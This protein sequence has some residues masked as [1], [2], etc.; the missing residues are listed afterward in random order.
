MSVQR[1]FDELST[2]DEPNVAISH[3]YQLTLTCYLPPSTLDG[4]LLQTVTIYKRRHIIQHE[5]ML[6]TLWSEHDGKHF[7]ILVERTI[8]FP[9]VLGFSLTRSRNT[10]LSND[11][12]RVLQAGDTLIHKS[13]GDAIWTL[14][15]PGV[16][17]RF[18]INLL[19]LAT[20]LRTVR[21]VD[22]GREYHTIDRNCFW[23]VRMA[24]LAII[25]LAQRAHAPNQ[26]AIATTEEAEMHLGRCG[27]IR[28][29]GHRAHDQDDVQQLVD[30]YEEVYQELRRNHVSD[31]SVLPLRSSLTL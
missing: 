6:F 16:A 31:V 24:R 8:D 29:D 17:S 27:C 3:F 28:L 7:Q 1:I 5:A 10:K 19:Q 13:Y 12:A 25:C 20:L 23:L 26:V 21:Q 22:R 15:M 14:T 11:T 9:S 18:S 4:C 30:S 2:P